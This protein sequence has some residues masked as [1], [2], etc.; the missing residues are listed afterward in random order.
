MDEN[1]TDEK[2]GIDARF[3][4][5]SF[6]PRATGDVSLTMTSCQIPSR[7]EKIAMMDLQGETCRVVIAPPG[8]TEIAVDVSD[9]PPAGLTHPN[10]KT[11]SQRLRACLYV[12]WKTKPDGKS[13]NFET[14]YRNSMEDIIGGVKEKLPRE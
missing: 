8:A 11:P 7:D 5:T 10:A 12:L 3:V 13:T 14:F 9:E 1:T 2:K 6:R 4:V